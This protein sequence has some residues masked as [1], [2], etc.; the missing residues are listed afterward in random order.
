VI[1]LDGLTMFVTST[2]ST[3]VVS[4]ETRLHFT[5][6]GKRVSARYA[7]GRV[8]R[9]RLAGRWVDHTLRFRYVQREDG[10]AIHAGHSICD[11][12]QLPDGRLRVIEH[13]AWSTRT[14]SGIN[15]FEELPRVD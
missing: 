15:V 1:D 8:A 6:R 10:P 7:G 2:A 4:E 12:E 3:G 13:F 11:V 9:G 14:G 5:Q